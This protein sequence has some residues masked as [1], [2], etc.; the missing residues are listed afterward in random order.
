[1]IKRIIS[2]LSAFYFSITYFFTKKYFTRYW[3][4]SIQFLVLVRNSF[5]PSIIRSKDFHLD[6]ISKLQI[7]MFYCK[8]RMS[9]RLHL[10][11]ISILNI[12]NSKV[13]KSVTFSLLNHY[14]DFNE[15]C[16]E[17]EEGHSLLFTVIISIQVRGDAV[18]S[19]V[20]LRLT[21]T[22]RTL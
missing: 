1:M 20:F 5:L 4:L 18:K 2:F 16:V 21:F 17:I 14:I 12:I 15:I 8:A 6:L 13:K 22:R 7:N 3:P 19:Q 10:L 11:V 9:M